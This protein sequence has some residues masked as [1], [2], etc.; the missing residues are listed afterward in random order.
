MHHEPSGT[1]AGI[2]ACVMIDARYLRTKTSGIGRYTEHIIP[3]MLALDPT[4]RLK[5]ITHPERPVPF[6]HERV[7]C[8]R[9]GAPANSLQ[10]RF[11]LA[12]AVSFEGVDLFHSPFNILPA[13]L[14]V[15]AVFT[16]H[17]IMWLLDPRFC[18]TSRVGLLVTG[19]FYRELI[20][21]SAAEA[22]RVMTV[23]HHSK[24]AIESYF[25]ELHGRVDVTYNGLDTF[26]HERPEAERWGQ[27][28]GLLGG[29][30]RYVLVVGQGSPY[31]NHGG[32]LAG[33]LHAFRDDPDMHLVLVRRFTRGQQ[34]D[35]K[36]LLRDPAIKRRIIHLPYVTGEQLRA[37]Y[38][39]AQ[40]FL[41]P[42]LY[43]GFGLPPLEAMACGA[44]VVTSHDGAMAEVCGDAALKVDPRDH[45]AIGEALRQIAQDGALAARLREAGLRHAATFT[46]RRSA[47][48]V[49]AT[50][51]AALGR[52]A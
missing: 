8:T 18:T 28:A 27:V 6:E 42:S 5:L 36:E 10:T 39:C 41:F 16:L 29:K 23:S 45:A 30:K 44:P 37:L 25:P 9:F 32:A 13:R 22:R 24:E 14:P 1:T 12:R 52:P 43:E 21:R 47:E 19:T 26:F 4:L 33:F 35:V 31:K 2:D 15:P 34:A 46:W 17:D 7:S 38:G 40:T 50:Y 49:L 3:E 20:P 48:Q 11:G 51:R